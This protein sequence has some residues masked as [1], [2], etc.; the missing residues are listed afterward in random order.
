MSNHNKRDNN[1]NIALCCHS[2]HLAGDN[3]SSRLPSAENELEFTDNMG[4]DSENPPTLA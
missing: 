3:Q 2:C 4:L 1:H